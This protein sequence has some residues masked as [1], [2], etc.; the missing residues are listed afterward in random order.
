MKSK[1]RKTAYRFSEIIL[2]L[3]ALA[4]WLF[5]LYKII[6]YISSLNLR[7]FGKA[8]G[9]EYSW[10]YPLEP[11]LPPNPPC[12]PPCPPSCPTSVTPSPIPTPTLPVQTPTPTPTPSEEPLPTPIP[13]VTPI[14][15]SPPVGGIVNETGGGGPAVGG[16]SSCGAQTP[17]AP[18][19]KSL[20][21]LGGGEVELFWD[22]VE[23]STHYSISY[24]PS[25]GNYLYGV[26]NTGKTTSFKIGALRKGRYC[27]A[28]RAVNDCAPGELSN[29]RC[30][31]E[32]L[33]VTKVLG[34]STL[35]ATGGFEEKMLQILFIIGCVCLATGLKLLFPAKR[36]A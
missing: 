1:I 33:G 15:T 7:T 28:V 9:L 26:P 36:L 11:P 27:F 17:P 30:T 6:S 24:G 20:K 10:E 2:L 31:G 35:G 8:F 32:V 22:P 21:I 18:Y 4:V 5:S 12:P 16:P 19:L 13:T 3:F 25:L 14:P 29:E 34:V 23:P